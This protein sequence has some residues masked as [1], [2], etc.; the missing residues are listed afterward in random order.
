MPSKK[1]IFSQ[2]SI[3]V[4]GAREHNLKHVDVDLPRERLVVVSGVSGSGKST[5]AFDTIFAEG[6]R[7]YVESLSA[8]ARQFLGQMVKPEV[9]SVSGLSPAVAIDQKTR[10]SNPRSTVGTVTELWDYM[11]VLWA[12]V[13]KLHCAACSWDGELSAATVSQMVDSIL[14]KAPEGSRIQVLAPLVEGRKGVH[15]TVLAD[16]QS[17]GYVR[18]RVDGKV[19]DIGDVSLDKNKK[20]VIDCVVDRLVVKSQNLA[21]TRQRLTESIEASLNVSPDTVKVVIGDRKDLVLSAAL[22]CPQCGEN[23]SEPEPKSFSFNSPYGACS[24]CSGLGTAWDVDYDACF[25]DDALSIE[26]GAVAPW[27]G[28]RSGGWC[29]EVLRRV[30]SQ[31]GVNLDVPIKSLP[32][33]SLALLWEGSSET[34]QARG[35]GRTMKFQIEGVRPWVLRRHREASDAGRERMSR[36]VKSVPCQKCQGARLH[37][38]AR[39]VTVGGVSI[40]E[41]ASWSIDNLAQWLDGLKLDARSWN[42]AESL[43]REIRA[44][45]QFLLDVGLPYLSLDRSAGSLS[46]GEAQRIRLA[47]QI[48]S[49][50]VGVLYVLDEPSIGLHPRDNQR[51]LDSLVALRDLGNTVLVVE[52]DETTLRAAD[53]LVD[54]GPGAGELGGRVVA[55]GTPGQVEKVTKSPTGRWLSGRDKVEVPLSRRT[56]NGLSLGIRDATAHNLEKVKVD[57]PL[58]KLVVVTGVSGSGKSTLI[59]DLFEP[60]LARALGSVTA[61]P[62]GKIRL[63]GAENVDRVINIDQNPIGR[64]PR[65]NAATY[66]GV[67][68]KI[69]ALYATT[70]YAKERGWLQ[71]RFSFNVPSHNGGGRCEACQG[72]GSV[73]IEMHFLADVWVPCE[74]CGGTRYDDATLQARFKGKSISDVLNMT[75]SDAAKLF[76]N[77]ATIC[78]QLRVLESVGL[79]YLRVGQSAT[80]LSG[81][82]A[83]RVKLAS[84]LQK[85]STGKTLYVLDE[86]T[87]GLHM[88][89]VAKLLSVLDH[90]VDGGNTVVVIE[91]NTDVM[92]RADWIVDLGPEGGAGGGKV[93]AQ[94]T[95][96]DVALAKTHTA[97]ALR[98][99]LSL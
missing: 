74:V 82:E 65:S 20:H 96:E 88:A 62:L 85:R 13:G 21:S 89:D 38:K 2:G 6:Q 80:T 4:R 9:E 73:R 32:K 30:G 91:H 10:S 26:Q 7:R 42:V 67:F 94:G 43:V 87:T 98:D 37:P 47:S 79:G 50:L 27:A 75:I 45:V 93:V 92:K 52:H 86:P 53:W 1:Q 61:R 22:R 49:G 77:Q 55:E 25:P 76:E 83:Q 81:G 18:V 66:T 24:F 70:T 14:D 36:Y 34:H 5:L 97:A 90:L 19:L 59:G 11:R 15:A 40:T 60:A 16:L 35:W 17:R 28:S 44:R 12:R 33:K 64:T 63:L 54:I 29:L 48:G 68:D 78:R 71:G 23:Y 95:P 31:V 3:S 56:G 8:Y 41:A 58:G 72:E 57:V 84:E 46:G 51:L 69:R 99:A 39:A